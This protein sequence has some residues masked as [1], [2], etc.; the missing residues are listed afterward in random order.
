MIFFQG[1]L[2]QILLEIVELVDLSDYF[3]IIQEPKFFSML[4]LFL[5]LEIDFEQQK[6]VIHINLFILFIIFNPSILFLI[7]II[8]FLVLLLK[9][10]TKKL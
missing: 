2:S 5:Y 4:N 7:F 9:N 1:Y 10:E 8:I 6:I 3:Y